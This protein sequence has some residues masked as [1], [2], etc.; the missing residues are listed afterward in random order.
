MAVGKLLNENDLAGTRR[1]GGCQVRP[2]SL[3]TR[4][5]V[6]IGFCG[7]TQQSGKIA[8]AERP[9][10]FPNRTSAVP[11]GRS[12]LNNCF[13]R[14][15]RHSAP[16]LREDGPPPAPPHDWAPTKEQAGTKRLFAINL[17]SPKRSLGGA[18]VNH[19]YTPST[20]FIFTFFG[21]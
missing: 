5:C 1:V 3:G 4:V 19:F 20:A 6:F 13:R 8:R 21:L 12:S 17:E 7:A 10:I 15:R 18:K 9:T 16:A 14:R 2:R 11:V